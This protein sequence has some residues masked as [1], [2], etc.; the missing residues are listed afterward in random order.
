MIYILDV[1]TKPNLE[2][3]ELFASEIKAPGNY[4]DPKKIAQYIAIE[5]GKMFKRMAT[6]VD[7]CQIAC[8][9]LKELGK[10]GE[11][12][13]LED[14]GRILLA[15]TSLHLVTFNG[16]Q[17]D[18]PILIKHGVKQGI[19]LPYQELIEATRMWSSSNHTDLMELL[20]FGQDW[21]SLDKYLQI[22]CGVKK[23]EVDFEQ[24]S[25]G[26]LEQ[27]CLEDLGLTEMLYE[28]FSWLV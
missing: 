28:K 20:S 26:E 16:K 13:T 11:L 21:L 2:L 5:K 19:K 10:P 3:E 15:D 6:S 24:I 27:H 23:K 8:I 14:L 1:E 12:V 4:K 22:Y 17:F 25:Q 18:L 7:Y 9:G